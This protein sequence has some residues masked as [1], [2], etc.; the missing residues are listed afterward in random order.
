MTRSL[1][2]AAEAAS[3]AAH[4]RPVLLVALDLASG[5][6]RFSTADRTLSF[7]GEDYLAV[8]DLGRIAP[9]GEPTDLSVEGVAI[10]LSGIPP[11]YIDV[12][13]AENVQG[14]R[15][16]L[17]L[18]FL[19][20]GYAL[21]DEPVLI[22]RGRMDTMDIRLGETATVVA[23]VENRLADWDR[24]R[25]RR[26]THA[27]QIARFPADKGL[28]FVSQAAEREILWGRG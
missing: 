24:P 9:F 11:S 8:G 26:Y 25:V 18:G 27:D 6:V 1:T 7:A 12:A 23:T 10:E 5:P 19:D 2:E 22:F 21:I 17:W 13:M 20:E 15:A 14:R 28:E 4:L 16:R 3:L